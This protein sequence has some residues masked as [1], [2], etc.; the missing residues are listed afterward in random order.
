VG[1]GYLDNVQ[2]AYDFCVNCTFIL[3][4][5]ASG[6]QEPNGFAS[7]RKPDPLENFLIRPRGYLTF[8]FQFLVIWILWI[9]PILVLEL[10]TWMPQAQRS[11]CFC[12]MP[13]EI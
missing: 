8:S 2:F 9:T 11:R 10:N 3:S 5:N 6:Y 4:P 1:Y 12:S 7:S 13:L